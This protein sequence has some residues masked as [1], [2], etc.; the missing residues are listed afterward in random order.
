MSDA[1]ELLPLAQLKPG[2]VLSSELL[3]RNGM[4]LLAGGAVL[5]E[6]TIASLARHGIDTVAVLRTP[7]RQAP[8]DLAAVQARLDH[9]FRKNERDNHGDWATGLLRRYIEDYRLGRHPQQEVA[10]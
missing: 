9:V 8:V 3:D 6:S 7:S 1:Y 2:M 4:V 5:A 10:P